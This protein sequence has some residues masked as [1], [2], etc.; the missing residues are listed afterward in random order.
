[1]DDDGLIAVG[2]LEELEDHAGDAD[3]VE[4]G[5]LG[6]F[7]FGVFL[8]DDAD[9]FFAGH[10]FI[11]EIFAFLPADVEGHD[12]AGE[13]DDVADGQNGQQRGDGQ[14]LAVAGRADDGCPCV[15]LDDLGF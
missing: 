14:L 7:D 3:G 1:M 8:G 4:I 12:G 13:D 5:V 2:E 15:T 6:V 11:E 9:E 10:D